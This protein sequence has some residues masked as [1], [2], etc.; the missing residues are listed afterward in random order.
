[1]EEELT[2]ED[3]ELVEEAKEL[4]RERY[5]R[6]RHHIA[7]A[8][9]TVGGRVHK[10][11]HVEA[12][13]GR[14]ALCAEAV[15]IGR[16]RTEGSEFVD[17]IVA[18]RSPGAGAGT[19]RMEVVSPCGMCRELISDYGSGA[20]VIIMVKGRMRKAKIGTLLPERFE[21]SDHGISGS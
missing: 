16:M 21:P 14:I 11:I 8:L 19:D 1:M 17:T 18:V 4:I 5:D 7:S 10:G 3:L 9:R 6:D 13:V 2:K 15:A 20:K 12:S